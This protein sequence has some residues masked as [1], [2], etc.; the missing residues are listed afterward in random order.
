MQHAREKERRPPQDKEKQDPPETVDVTDMFLGDQHDV[1]HRCRNV[2]EGDPPEIAPE[3]ARRF[4]P[5]PEMRLP[6]PIR[7]SGFQRK[8]D[9]EQLHSHRNQA[10]PEAM[11]A[12]LKNEVH[13]NREVIGIRSAKD[14]AEVHCADGT[15]YRAGRVIC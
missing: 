4:L 2:S 12:G 3:A 5:P 10:I 9:R 1:D 6:E 14:G 13:L 15:V 7:P 8:T 11:A